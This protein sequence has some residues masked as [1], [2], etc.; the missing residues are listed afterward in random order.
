MPVNIDKLISLF[1]GVV[2]YHATIYATLCDQNTKVGLIRFEVTV[3]W[4]K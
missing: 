3:V 4:Q 1:D 2:D